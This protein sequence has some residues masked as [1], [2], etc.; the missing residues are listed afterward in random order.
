MPPKNRV[1]IVEDDPAFLAAL[2]RLLMRMGH[3]VRA[4][5]SVGE[6]LA[7]LESWVP[8]HAILDLMLPDENGLMVLHVMRERRLPVRVAIISALPVRGN[9]AELAELKPDAIFQK[10]LDLFTLGGW[11]A[12]QAD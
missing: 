5:A 11:L 4:V 6:A 1:L 3:E 10:P 8:N 2:S 7:I 9:S 12:S